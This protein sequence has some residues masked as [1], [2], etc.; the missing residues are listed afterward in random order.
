MSST[1]TST[2]R[3]RHGVKVE[4][5]TGFDKVEL[6]L[7]C[8]ISI[9]AEE[10]LRAAWFL[11]AEP[12]QEIASMEAATKVG[13][14][15][16]SRWRLDPHLEHMVKVMARTPEDNNSLMERSV[17]EGRFS[18]MIAM[19]LISVDSAMR[20]SALGGTLT[21]DARASHPWAAALCARD[22]R[23]ELAAPAV[24][25]HRAKCR[26]LREE[27]K[28]AAVGRGGPEA[29]KAWPRGGAP[30]VNLRV[31]RFGAFHRARIEV[32][33]EGDGQEGK[34]KLREIVSR[35]NA[36]L[37]PWIGYVF[38]W[39][40][41]SAGAPARGAISFCPSW[42]HCAIVIK[43][44]GS[45]SD[46]A[47][48]TRF[49]ISGEGKPPW[50][51]QARAAGVELPLV[52]QKR[53]RRAVSLLWGLGLSGKRTDWAGALWLFGA[54]ESS[55]RPALTEFGGWARP[56]SGLGPGSGVGS[57]RNFE[58]ASEADFVEL[59]VAVNAALMWIE[60]EGICAESC[61]VLLGIGKV[62][63]PQLLV[64]QIEAH[65][66]RDGAYGPHTAA[67]MAGLSLMS[68]EQ[69][70][71]RAQTKNAEPRRPRL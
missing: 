9:R 22:P 70:T 68:L 51:E 54:P 62:I 1:S 61:E 34:R 43:A 32:A 64:D 2:S 69:S 15:S 37:W 6:H 33:L 45:R 20:L 67:A 48:G 23:W 41:A 16:G 29:W 49:E 7:P 10:A 56:P 14:K 24:K 13:I 17:E 30:D 27:A 35:L 50:A 31:S 38:D 5:E 44:V 55:E 59:N 58:R 12:Y 4:V 25:P 66:E 46:F 65:Q 40:P 71:G 60:K 3:G 8:V 52:A 42:V 21:A 47:T 28:A 36:P 26:A 39:T 11:A 53:P 18:V 19:G 57:L 63:D